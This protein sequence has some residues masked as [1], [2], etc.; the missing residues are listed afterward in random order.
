M[1]ALPS[2]WH[3][4]PLP[5]K[6]RLR[7]RLQTDL[8]PS[9]PRPDQL[10]PDGDWHVWLILAGRGWGKTRTGAEWLAAET[11]N[12]PGLSWAV[13]APTYRD[14]RDVCVEDPKSGLLQALTEARVKTYNRSLGEIELT[15][16][17]KVFMLS[18]DEPDRFRGKNLAGAWCD[19]LASW[20]YPA[21]WHEGL[22]PALRIGNHPRVVVTTT[23]R[24]T[25]LMRELVKRGKA[26]DGV[27]LTTGSTFANRRG[28]STVALAELRLRY[29]GTL[30]GRQEL[31]AELLDETPGALWTRAV[32][33]GCH[34]PAHPDLAC[35]VVAVD[36]AVTAS[37][38]SDETGIVAAGVGTDG[39]C[40]VLADVSLRDTP[41]AWATAAVDL[42]DQ[43]AGDRIVAETNNG[44]D[45]VETVLRSVDPSVP[46]RK[47]TAS[48][49][50][51]VR[52]QP[53]AAL[54]EQ[55]R[56]HHVGTFTELEDQLV[57]WTPESGSSP[58]RLDALVWAVTDL[59][60]AEKPRR[61]GL[62]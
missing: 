30:I 17:T 6:A 48:R 18:A 50:K 23:P 51:Q 42:Y 10:P 44:G 20:R 53:V 12:V 47:V 56:V 45:L 31:E 46:V 2:D 59:M 41:Q 37:E 28:L 22:I 54:Y 15:D 61:G 38:T 55:G 4:W 5:A 26:S 60:L 21:A 29:E 8:H 35:V 40:Y 52:A 43:V 14:V 1:S 36:P 25:A 19:E 27:H 3:D 16:G 9:D 34:V 49:G 32:V 13:A 57:T 58:D 11:L 33:E 62:R 7:W 39:H 24:P